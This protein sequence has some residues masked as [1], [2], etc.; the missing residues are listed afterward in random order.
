MALGCGTD[1]PDLRP[2]PRLAAALGTI[3]LQPEVGRF[4]PAPVRITEVINCV[5]EVIVREYYL[6]LNT[7]DANGHKGF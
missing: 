7:K 1:P 3:G 6:I 2:A 4:V 5:S